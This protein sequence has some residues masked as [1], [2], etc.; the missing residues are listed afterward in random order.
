MK[1]GYLFELSGCEA[2]TEGGP[3][4]KYHVVAY[5]VKVHNT[6]TRAFCSDQSAAVKTNASGS[7]QACL[8]SGMPLQ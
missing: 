8:E 5:P 2:A 4:V 3:K 6:G 7:P 1:N